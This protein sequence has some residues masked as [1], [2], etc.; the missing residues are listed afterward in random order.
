LKIELYPTKEN[1]VSKA[2]IENMLGKT[3]QFKTCMY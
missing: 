2:I 3:Q 1:N